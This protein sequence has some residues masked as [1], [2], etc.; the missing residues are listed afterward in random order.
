MLMERQHCAG[1]LANPEQG[2]CLHGFAVDNN[3]HSWPRPYTV[4]SCSILQTIYFIDKENSEPQEMET[5]L[6]CWLNPSHRDD[7]CCRRQAVGT[8]TGSPLPLS[9]EGA[10]G[11]LDV[12]QLQ[13]AGS[14]QQRLHVLLIN[15]QVTV[16]GK[17]DQSLKCT[18]QWGERVGNLL[19]SINLKQ[20]T[21]NRIT[22]WPGFKRT[23]MIIQFQPPCYV[24]G[25]QPP[26]QAA[27][28]HI[29]PG[30]ECLLVQFME[31]R[32]SSLAH[33]TLSPAKDLL[34]CT[35][36]WGIYLGSIPCMTISSCLHSIMSLVNMAWK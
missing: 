19:N 32:L 1:Y 20:G 7:S 9:E 17:V 22:E 5:F 4:P 15:R 30:L 34:S 3:S 25:R 23:T 29:Q 36:A 6:S 26:D 35:G 10:A 28:S 16:V 18:E 33:A 12:L 14:H 27:Q 31:G 2:K 24:Q 8:L 13:E 11:I 21:T